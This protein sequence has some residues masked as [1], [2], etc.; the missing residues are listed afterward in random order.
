MEEKREEKEG[1]DLGGGGKEGDRRLLPR[2][3]SSIPSFSFFPSWLVAASGV[4]SGQEGGRREGGRRGEEKDC[5]SYFF[6]LL[7]LLSCCAIGRRGAEGWLLFCLE[8][9]RETLAK[10]CLCH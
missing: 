6:L 3:P 1:V 4:P 2:R 9:E 7:L 8:E 5:N 10:F